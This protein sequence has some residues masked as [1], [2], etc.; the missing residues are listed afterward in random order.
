M[1]TLDPVSV[2]V[3]LVVD[4]DIISFTSCDAEN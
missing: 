1:A 4:G 2:E 3:M